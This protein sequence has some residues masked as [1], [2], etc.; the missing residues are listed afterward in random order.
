[1]VKVSTYSVCLW[2]FRS[3]IIIARIH[4]AFRSSRR[5]HR[6]ASF[7]RVTRACGRTPATLH[8]PGPSLSSL[9]PSRTRMSIYRL[10]KMM[11]MP[12][13]SLSMRRH[14][15]HS[16]QHY[17]LLNV[18]RTKSPRLT[19]LNGGSQRGTAS[20]VGRT[21]TV[22]HKIMYGSCMQCRFP[23]PC[24]K[25]WLSS[26]QRGSSGGGIMLSLELKWRELA[27][28]AHL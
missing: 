2:L 21:N 12:Q 17:P 20:E 7:P 15:R 18:H 10:L 28:Q 27:S 24:G 16:L 4:V 8:V 11:R 25:R 3:Q 19:R 26:V 9:L 6:A 13:R 14:L 5:W 1:M 22:C 23:E